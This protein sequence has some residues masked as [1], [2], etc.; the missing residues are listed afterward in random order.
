MEQNRSMG[1]TRVLVEG[2]LVVALTVLLSEWKIWK[3]PQGGS[4]TLGDVPLLIFALRHGAKYGIGTGLVAGLLRLLLGGYVLTPV[5][6]ALDYP[7]AYGAIGLA[8]LLKDVGPAGAAGV[9]L[10]SAGRL[11]CNVISGAVF[12]GQYAPAGQNPWVYSLIY[13]ATYMVPNAIIGI[14][15]TAILLPRLKRF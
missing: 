5:Q 15:I 7:I 9:V 6:A 1:K 8:G 4:I 3:M 2:A 13:N 11:L 10:G 12:F 14:V